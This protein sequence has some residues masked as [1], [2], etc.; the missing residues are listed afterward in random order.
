MFHQFIP[1]KQLAGHLLISQKQNNWGVTL[2][3]KELV[4]Q[5]PHLSYHIFLDDVLGI[6]P[7]SFPASH[8]P[9]QMR[10]EAWLEP[11]YAKK[12][13]KLSVTK[14]NIINRQGLLT[15]GPT[16]LILPLNERFL[17]YVEKYAGF[18]HIEVEKKEAPRDEDT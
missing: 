12:Y 4:F 8:R 10:E 15:G 13:Y 18:A 3:T 6:L 11:T 1:V 17:E 14:L 16:D 5:K 7:Y 9:L 2:T